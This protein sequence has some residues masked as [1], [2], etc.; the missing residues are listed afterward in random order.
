M[1]W[2]LT[3]TAA[4]LLALLGQYLVLKNWAAKDHFLGGYMTA[5]LVSLYL[6]KGKKL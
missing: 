6:D 1:K 5:M 2:F 3:T 4:V